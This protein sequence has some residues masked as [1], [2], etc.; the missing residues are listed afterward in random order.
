MRKKYFSVYLNRKHPSI[1]HTLEKEKDRQLQL[2]DVINN[3]STIGCPAK[4]CIQLKMFIFE[5]V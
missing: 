3:D 5:K 1:K 4:E 2:S